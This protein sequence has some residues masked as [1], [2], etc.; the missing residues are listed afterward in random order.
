MKS[1]SPVPHLV[2]NILALMVLLLALPC[3]FANGKS[4]KTATRYISPTGRD[5]NSGTANQPWGTFDFAVAKLKPGDTLVL[6][7]GI[8]NSRNSGF[9]SVNCSTDTRNG[10]RDAPIT[11]QAE[12]ERQAFLQGNGVLGPFVIRECSYWNVIGLHVENHVDTPLAKTNVHNMTLENCDH[13]TIRRNLV[14][15]VNR[16]F[17][18][19][20]L[21]LSHVTNTLIE[22]NEIYF[23]NRHAIVLA[24][25]N[26]SNMGHN[27]VRRNYANSREYADCTLPGC[28]QSDDPSQGDAA[29]IAYPN[30][31]DVFENNISENNQRG[32]EIEAA[33]VP[34]GSSNN[35]WLG[36]IS[37]HD[38][39]GARFAARCEESQSDACMPQNSKLENFVAVDSTSM[40]LY[41]RSAK[42]TSCTNCAI[43]AGPH[44]SAEF[45]GVDAD[46]AGVNLGDGNYSIFLTNTSLVGDG[47]GIAV[48]LDT[49]PGNWTWKVEHVNIYD[50]RTNFR[51]ALE[52]AN[53]VASYK[54]PN[55][56]TCYLWLP[57]N[58]PLKRAGIKALDIGANI[59]YRYEN[60]ELTNSPLWSKGGDFPH[61]AI[62]SGLN[63]VRGSSLIDL[64]DRLNINKNGCSFPGGYQGW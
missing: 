16:Y 14:A 8:Y 15:Y 57:D 54:N 60:G 36:D 38:S 9:V 50:F 42:A 62:V 63:D 46:Q 35:Q 61:G 24:N 37:L 2:R 34:Y 31:D 64:M 5:S 32:M 33:W 11:I 28:R 1:T 12:H 51:P 45:V 19:H 49:H 21:L 7:D 4:G 3:V 41:S 22:E 6:K 59:L 27:V 47:R 56:G 43:F 18:D 30:G 26:G 39:Y 23:F 20:A 52:K 40:G 48:E 29:F 55:L 25:G 53:L 58:S 17:N 44:S 13:L 10:S